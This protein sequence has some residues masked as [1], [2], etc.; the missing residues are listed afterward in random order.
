M[1]TSLE[2][3]KKDKVQ[4]LHKM[5]CKVYAVKFI[6]NESLYCTALGFIRKMKNIIPNKIYLTVG[7]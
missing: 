2:H 4:V 1:F 3:E 5:K 7:I 6:Q